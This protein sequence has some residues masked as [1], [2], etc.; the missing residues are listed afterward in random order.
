MF[1]YI[2]LAVLLTTGLAQNTLEIDKKINIEL[3]SKT[4]TNYT[5]Q[6]S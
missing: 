1:K 3:K 2:F 4:P 6:L 5:A